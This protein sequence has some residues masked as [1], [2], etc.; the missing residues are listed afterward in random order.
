MIRGP[1]TKSWSLFYFGDF[2]SGLCSLYKEL[3]KNQLLNFLWNFQK[4]S[5]NAQSVRY[6]MSMNLLNFPKW[7]SAFWICLV[8]DWLEHPFNV[9]LTSIRAKKRCSSYFLLANALNRFSNDEAYDLN[10]IVYTFPDYRKHFSDYIFRFLRN[11]LNSR[12]F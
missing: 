1:Y 9:E 5:E 3:W 11:G 12:P 2:K 6:S 4:A 7:P 10:D 8:C